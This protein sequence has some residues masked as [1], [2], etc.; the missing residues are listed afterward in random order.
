MQIVQTA[1]QWNTR[2][3]DRMI[4]VEMDETGESFTIQKSTYEVNNQHYWLQVHDRKYWSNMKAE[5]INQFNYDR[6]D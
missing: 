4:L 1:L 3:G 6:N 2:F 5:K